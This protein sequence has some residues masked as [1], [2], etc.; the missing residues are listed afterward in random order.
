MTKVA[1]TSQLCAYTQEYFFQ[2]EFESQSWFTNS[3]P[4][5]HITPYNVY[6][7]NKKPCVGGSE[8]HVGNCQSLEINLI[9]STCFF[10][11]FSY[12]SQSILDREYPLSH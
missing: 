6:L 9:G 11:K 2:Y 3:G 12:N 7:Q 4:S 1:T 8:I 10:S 5:R